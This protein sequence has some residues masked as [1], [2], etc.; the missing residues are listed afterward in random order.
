M[1]THVTGLKYDE[2]ADR[3]RAAA[4][5]AAATTAGRVVKTHRLFTDELTHTKAAIVDGT[6]RLAAAIAGRVVAKGVVAAL[7]TNDPA[8]GDKEPFFLVPKTQQMLSDGTVYFKAG[9]VEQGFHTTNV[10]KALEDALTAEV[11]I[12]SDAVG[13][14]GLSELDAQLHLNRPAVGHI[15]RK[16]GYDDDDGLDDE[17]DCSWAHLSG[18]N[19]PN[20]ETR[21][22]AAVARACAMGLAP[23]PQMT[24]WIVLGI[25]N[26]WCGAGPVSAIPFTTSTVSEGTLQAWSFF[27]K[28]GNTWEPLTP[29]SQ[30]L[31]VQV[32]R[33]A[34]DVSFWFETD[35]TVSHSYPLNPAPSGQVQM[36]DAVWIVGL[37][38]ARCRT[39][40]TNGTKLTEVYSCKPVPAMYP[41]DRCLPFQFIGLHADAF[42][43]HEDR[44]DNEATWWDITNADPTEEFLESRSSALL[45]QCLGEREPPVQD[46]LGRAPFTT[47]WDHAWD[48]VVT[49]AIPVFK[50]TT[51]ATL[52]QSR[53]H[54]R[55]PMPVTRPIRCTTTRS[56][57]WV[58]QGVSVATDSLGATLVY[59]ERKT[60]HHEPRG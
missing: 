44:V 32:G 51:M 5:A 41:H 20:N 55:D 30:P 60:R 39:E 40:P 1:H 12:A 10:A 7:I 34:L 48:E 38:G 24:E 2:G 47:D 11:N 33:T 14:D 27:V 49:A 4:F 17:D 26:T 37:G 18:Y 23:V 15:N 13:S 45:R 19:N 28:R 6:K 25:K 58:G 31:I 9:A 54:A 57:W 56:G 35:S 52:V 8:E 50:N 16:R 36:T 43:I 53:A 46:L 29:G 3:V 59:I 22:R 21:D 42:F